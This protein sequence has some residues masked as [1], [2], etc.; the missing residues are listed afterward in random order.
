MRNFA[1]AAVLI[2]LAASAF[3]AAPVPRKSP[4]FVVT[5]P[6][7]KQI[8]LSSFKGK[9]VVVTFMYTTCPHCQHEAQMVTKLQKDY[10]ARGFQA[11]GAAFNF[12]DTDANGV[13]SATV[14][15]FISDFGVGYPV[16]Y[17]SQNAVQSYLGLSVMDRYVVP[18]VAIIDRKGN[19]VKQSDAT[20]GSEELQTEATLRAIVEKLLKESAATSGAIPA[21]KTVA[22][23]N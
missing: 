8:S 6:S 7:G 9:V 4:D 22:K 13:K 2:A 23:A 10:A 5:D 19:V 18:Q 16:G 17:A 20:M 12:Q 1:S 14:A 11:L 3:G 21:G 15:K